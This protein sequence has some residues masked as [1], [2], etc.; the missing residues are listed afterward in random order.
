MKFSSDYVQIILNSRSLHRSFSSTLL[1]ACFFF[2]LILMKYT[3]ITNL[4]T[5]SLKQVQSFLLRTYKIPNTINYERWKEAEKDCEMENVFFGI[6]KNNVGGTEDD[7]RSEQVEDCAFRE[8]F[9]C[10]V[11][12]SII[13]WKLLSRYD[14]LPCGG[15]IHHLLWTLFFMKTYS[16]SK[17][18]A[19]TAGTDEKT[20]RKWV[21]LFIPALASLHTVVVS[22]WWWLMPYYSK[23]TLLILSNKST[24]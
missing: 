4:F 24:V 2:T 17:V 3:W 23:C 7:I 22:F 6:C 15:K 9:G 10:S 11:L 16:K 12:T 19:S 13:A 20:M 8:M 18:M 21:W 1:R 14:M 5:I